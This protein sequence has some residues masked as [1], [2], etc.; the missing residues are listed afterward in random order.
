MHQVQVSMN[1]L[2]EKQAGAWA[3]TDLRKAF[4][5]RY[6]NGRAGPDDE[7]LTD[8][9]AALIHQIPLSLPRMHNPFLVISP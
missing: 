4:L 7:I 8:L 3:D 1:S 9:D 5:D 6:T 2:K